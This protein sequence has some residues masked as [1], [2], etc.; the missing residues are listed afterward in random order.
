MARQKGHVK[1]VGTIGDIRH[2]KIKGQTGYFAGLVG[3]PTGEQVATAPEFERTRENMNEFG[4]SAKA[5]RSVRSV[6]SSILG[7]M[8]DSQLTGRLTAIMKKIN[9]ED[10]SEPR[11]YRAILISEQRKYLLGIT[12]NKNANFDSSFKAGADLVKTIKRGVADYTVGAFNPMDDIQ[13]PAGAT[14]FRLIFGL[15]VLSDFAYNATSDTYEPLKPEFHEL[16]A[17]TYS[18]YLP[19][20]APVPETVLNADLDTEDPVPDDCTIIAVAGIEF[21]QQVNENYYAFASGNALKV[22]DAY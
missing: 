5:G 21:F 22:V 6:F 7:K 9:L 11:G 17:I 18:N 19:L 4:G 10:Q 13:A 1:Y 16:S 3:G 20:T 15:G 8:T 12:F 2:F 14:H